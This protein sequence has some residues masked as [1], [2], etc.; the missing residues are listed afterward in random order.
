MLFPSRREADFESRIA[1]GEDQ[2]VSGI[3]ESGVEVIFEIKIIIFDFVS[4]LW[5]KFK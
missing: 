4:N 1:Q 5:E 2:K 3:G